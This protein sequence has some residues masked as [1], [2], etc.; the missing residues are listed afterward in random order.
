MT[1]NSCLKKI[2]TWEMCNQSL[3]K[4]VFTVGKVPWS[5]SEQYIACLNNEKETKFWLA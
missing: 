1:P 3:T 4:F 2:A 5:E